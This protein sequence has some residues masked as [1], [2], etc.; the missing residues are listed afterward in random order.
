MP[1]AHQKKK[2]HWIGRMLAAKWLYRFLGGNLLVIT[3]L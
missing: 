3:I 1:N 2:L